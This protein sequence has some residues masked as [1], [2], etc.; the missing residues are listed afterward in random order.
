MVDGDGCESDCT[1]TDP[2]DCGNGI[3]DAGET[4]DDGNNVNGDG[5]DE[6]C[7]DEVPGDVCGNSIVEVG[8]QCDDGNVIDGDGCDSTCQLEAGA[9]NNDGVVDPGEQCDDGNL[10]D[11]DGCESDCTLTNPADCGNNVLDAGETCDDGNN[12]NGDGCDEF[13]QDEVPGDV[14]GNSIIEIGETCDDGNVLDGDGCD[15]TCQLEPVGCAPQNLTAVG[16]SPFQIDTAW[17]D[18]CPNEVKFLLER[19]QGTCADLIKPYAQIVELGVNVTNHSDFGPVTLPNLAPNTSYAYRVRAELPGSQFS[20]Y[21]NCADATTHPDGGN[22]PHEPEHLIATA[23]SSSQIELNWVDNS[24]NE[25]AF[26][27]RRKQGDCIGDPVT[28]FAHVTDVGADTTQYIDDGLTSSTFYC[29]IIRAKNPNGESP[30]SNKDGDTTFPDPIDVPNPATNLVADPVSSSAI[31]VTWDD[32]AIDEWGFKIERNDDPNCDIGAGAFV[33][34]DQLAP[35]TVNYLDT[36]LT[37]NTKYCYRVRP[38]NGQGD[39][40]YSNEDDA[41]TLNP[42]GVPG[43]PINLTATTINEKSIEV[44]WD[45]IATDEDGYRLY[46]ADKP[47]PGGPV[48]LADADFIVID[49]NVPAVAGSGSTIKYQDNNLAANTNYCYYVIAFNGNGDSNPSN[50]DDDITKN[51]PVAVPTAPELISVTPNSPTQIELVFEDK[52][53]DESAFIVERHEGACGGGSF[54]ELAILPPEPS[55]GTSVTFFDNTVEPMTTYCYRIV[56]HNI[57]GDSYSNEMDATTPFSDDCP[58]G[59]IDADNICD[60]VH[61]GGDPG[62]G[63][64]GTDTDNDGTPDAGDTDT[65]NDGIPDIIEEGDGDLGTKPVDTDGD[66]TPD[67]RDTDSDNDCIPDSEEGYVDTDNDGTPDFQDTDSDDDGVLDGTNPDGDLST[68]GGPGGDGDGDGDNGPD[69]NCRVVVNPDQ[70]DS[71][72]DGIGDACDPDTSPACPGDQDCDGVPDG[73]DNCPNVAN[74]GQED[75][76]EDGIGDVCDPTPGIGGVPMSLFGGGCSLSTQL[77]TGSTTV[78]WMLLPALAFGVIRRRRK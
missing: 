34:I 31:T 47:C 16:V 57:I 40:A 60:G 68:C 19:F 2:G 32:N 9:C 69:D 22:I 29:Y 30:F 27:I 76:D 48:N 24:I 35:N 7:Q 72:G 64:D 49:P 43:D 54:E 58:A 44:A 53:D 6:F 67:F 37:A 11:G 20:D 71:D 52:S 78:L 26:E 25:S 70:A 18:T 61:D 8:E 12:V 23:I 55:T 15:S 10:V 41:T 65:D 56:A 5:C 74:P 75:A 39:G 21:S 33:E 45:D 1:L 42:G 4:C 46:R 62:E 17:I 66:G 63:P 77:A 50:W 28:D 36:G 3:L 38:F 14:C 59:D 51:I 13:C 73:E